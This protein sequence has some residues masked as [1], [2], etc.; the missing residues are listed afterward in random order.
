M[1]LGI[2]GAGQLSRMLCE[3]G[4]KIADTEIVVLT[5]GTDECVRDL[6][7]EVRTLKSESVEELT[8]AMAD[9]DFVTF[10]NEFVNLE[11]YKTVKSKN[12]V[13]FF[14][15]IEVIELMQNKISQKKLLDRLGI[16][17]A[18]WRKLEPQDPIGLERPIVLK[19]ARMGYD[20]KGTLIQRIPSPKIL[21]WI[22]AAW[23]K[24]IEI[25]AEN[26]VD[27]DMEVSLV[28]ARNWSGDI[29]FFPLVETHQVDGICHDV[30]GGLDSLKP[31]EV[32]IQQYAVKILEELNYV[33]VLAIE[34][35]VSK[36]KG[37]VVNEMAP[38][39][40]NSGHCTQ[41]S[42]N[43]SQFDLHLMSGLDL[44]LERPHKKSNFFGMWNLVPTVDVDKDY[45]AS[46]IQTLDDRFHLH[47]YGKSRLRKGRKMGH[48]N[49]MAP[50]VVQFK[51]LREM[52][53]LWERNWN[54]S[55]LK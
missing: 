18:K 37:I 13:K 33:G 42:S 3:A 9:L 39:V 6:G 50:D 10:E 1:K 19:W 17:T 38:R 4:K 32:P 29:V 52:L 53:K 45:S 8:S 55:L 43:V 36:M 22:K 35:F 46:E 51:E 5:T 48:I 28:C 26:I 49:F 47:W 15:S 20:G 31:Y 24:N 27:F 11:N 23:E 54:E 34:C 40:H 2:L 14:P 16:P 44:A 21:D 30:R 12:P 41:L 7:I 25:Y